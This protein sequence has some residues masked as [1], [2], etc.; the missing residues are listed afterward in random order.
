MKKAYKFLLAAAAVLALQQT[1]AWSQCLV[2][3]SSIKIFPYFQKKDTVIYSRET[4]SMSVVGQDTTTTKYFKEVYQVVCLQASDKKGYLLEETMLDVADLTE[5]KDT[6]DGAQKMRRDLSEALEKCNKGM[7]VRF[8]VDALGA[9]LTME[10]PDKVAAQIKQR[11]NAAYD[12]FLAQYPIVGTIMGKDA[13]TGMMNNMLSTPEQVM[14]NFEEM[15]QMFELHGKAY[16]YEVP[17]TIPM[18][19]PEYTRPGEVVFIALD[20]PYEGRPKQ[21]FDGYKII[22]QGET[23]QDAVAA[24]LTNM[25]KTYGRE[26][27]RDQLKAI[28]GDRMPSGEL[29]SLETLQN[30]YFY[31]GWPK[32]LFH[33]NTS[34]SPDDTSVIE[35]QYIVCEQRNWN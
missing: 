14:N 20:V 29:I 33:R 16:D 31:D 26:I 13:I 6:G 12:E 18:E 27:T 21:D 1:Q 9:N 28:L 11:M 10:N 8:R 2:R 23:Y 25:S 7:K 4:V 15:T 17:K 32:E 5:Y 3:D 24:T 19:G 22:I 35:I 34:I 30:E